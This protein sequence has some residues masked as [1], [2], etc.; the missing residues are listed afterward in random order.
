MAAFFIAGIRNARL[1]LD[2]W[3]KIDSI[4]KSDFVVVL[5]LWPKSENCPL[6]DG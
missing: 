3:L 6:E 1:I 4:A 2:F 5:A